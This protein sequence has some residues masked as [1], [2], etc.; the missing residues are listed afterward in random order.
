MYSMVLMAAISGAPGTSGADQPAPV[1]VGAPVVAM[2]GCTGCT[3][4]SSC[5]GCS[6]YSSCYGS[7]HGRGGFLGHKNSCH[8]CCGGMTY[9]SCHGCGGGLFHKHSC[10]GGYA[11]GCCGGYAAG[12]CGGSC[13]GYGSGYGYGYPAPSSYVYPS[14][15]VPVTTGTAPFYYTPGVIRST[16]AVVIP[17]VK[18]DDK[19]KAGASLKFELPANAV[20]F[21]DG[22]KTNGEGTTRSFY[23]PPLEAGQ[24][25]FYDVRAEIAID[26]KTVVEEKR[27]V[28]E[29][30]AEITESFPKVIAAATSA[31]TVAGK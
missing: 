30:G 15:A 25:Y 21:V 4:Y 23:T 7:C 5:Y 11:A 2:G 19:K 14:Y 17:E 29:A 26:G 20:L 24:K 1:V 8:G 10:H 27:V 12:C 16:P 3:G 9:A 31:T 6:G 22:A 13:Y 28:V 18:V